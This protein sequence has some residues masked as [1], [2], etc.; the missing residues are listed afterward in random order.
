VPE[1]LEN[2]AQAEAQAAR[3]VVAQDQ[4]LRELEG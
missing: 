3:D 1:G 2:L 4:E